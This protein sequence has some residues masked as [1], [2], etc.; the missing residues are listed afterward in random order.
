MRCRCSHVFSCR[1][2][3]RDVRVGHALESKSSKA[4][5]ASLIYHKPLMIDRGHRGFR[6]RE[7][8]HRKQLT[9]DEIG[10]SA[11]C[12]AGSSRRSP[13]EDGSFSEGGTLNNQLRKG[14]WLQRSFTLS[15]LNNLLI[16]VSQAL[17]NQLSAM[18]CFSALYERQIN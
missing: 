16:V 2:V 7:F 8:M 4:I 18:N 6:D 1:A 17:N 14:A 11:P 10:Q 15:T 13:S 9:I 5:S 3:V 12:H